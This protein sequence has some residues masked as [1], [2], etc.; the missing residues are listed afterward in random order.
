MLISS[1]LL[2]LATNVVFISAYCLTATKTMTVESAWFVVIAFAIITILSA[3]VIVW[4][5]KSIKKRE[6]RAKA[7]V[8]TAFSGLTGL[9]ALIFDV[10]FLTVLSVLLNK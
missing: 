4:N 1:I 10:S 9:F 3:I 2:F 6:V 7:I 5:A 8:G